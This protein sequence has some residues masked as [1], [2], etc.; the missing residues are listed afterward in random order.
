[1]MMMMKTK[2]DDMTMKLMSDRKAAQ[3]ATKIY[4][5]HK[6]GR[7]SD[8]Q[9]CQMLQDI[10][11]NFSTTQYYKQLDWFNFVKNNPNFFKK[12]A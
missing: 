4:E 9:A 10:S 6:L 7:I 8:S 5:A 3:L 11:M 2:E 12:S 1:M